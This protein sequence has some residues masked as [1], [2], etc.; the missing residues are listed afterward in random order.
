MTHVIG[1]VFLLFDGLM[2]I[3][4]TWSVYGPESRRLTA[5]E[6][7]AGAVYAGI[8]WILTVLGAYVA[9]VA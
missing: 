6:R 2:G 5:M 9:V 3:L 8:F 7:K 1:W 4:F